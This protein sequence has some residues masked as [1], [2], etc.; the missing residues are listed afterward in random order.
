MSYDI[1]QEYFVL[2]MLSEKC[3]GTTKSGQ[4]CKRDATISGYCHIHD[5]KIIDEHE[6][7]IQ[8]L[9]LKS[10]FKIPTKKFSERK[11]FKSVSK[12]IQIDGIN[13]DLRYSL[14]NFLYENILLDYCNSKAEICYGKKVE[15]FILYLWTDFFKKPL[16]ELQ[17][18]RISKDPI[19]Q[20]LR[21]KFDKLDWYEVYDLI[22]ATLNYFVNP[23]LVQKANN[24]LSRELSGFRFIGGILTDIT[25]EQEIQ[26]LEESLNDKSFSAVSSHLRCALTRM[27]DRKNPDYRNSIKES[28]SAV[29][30]IAKIISEDPKASLGQALKVLEN[31]QKIHS[32][33][34]AS[35]DKLYGYTS[36]EGGIRHG[37]LNEPNLTA[38][39][40]KF[41][42][43]SCTS[44]INY[45]KSKI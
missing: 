13:E 41:F 36:D 31:R 7:Q 27:S 45:L 2:T 19:L 29:E 24:L 35:F 6:A 44:F 3:K 4:R 28:I 26:M 32:S 43:L 23:L 14:W 39:D 20:N 38:A 21:S 1:I 37:M 9:K 12:I 40:A 5:P 22:E 17:F 15:S 8:S 10:E 18:I 34:R 33:L 11:G 30:S 25:T 16:D 42:L